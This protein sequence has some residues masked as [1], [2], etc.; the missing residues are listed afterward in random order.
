MPQQTLTRNRESRS[1]SGGPQRP[2]KDVITR[3]KLNRLPVWRRTE[4]R[5]SM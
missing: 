3:Q 1:R 2:S 4:I 5:K